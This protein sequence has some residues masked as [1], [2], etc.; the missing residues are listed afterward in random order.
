MNGIWQV[1]SQRYLSCCNRVAPGIAYTPTPR[2]EAIGKLLGNLRKLYM[3][4]ACMMASHLRGEPFRVRGGIVHETI[5]A[6][7]ISLLSGSNEL[8]G[9]SR[10]TEVREVPWHMPPSTIRFM[11]NNPRSMYDSPELRSSETAGGGYW[12]K[13]AYR[14]AITGIPETV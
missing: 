12:P 2:T 4:G 7:P 14:P 5:E 6:M 8:F 1:H 9:R 10:A 13:V 11:Y 3:K